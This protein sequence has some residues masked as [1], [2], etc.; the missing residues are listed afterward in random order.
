MTLLERRAWTMLVVA[1][2]AYTW[3]V[4][5]VL[6]RTGGT[7]SLADVPYA[8]ALLRSVVVAI[9]VNIAVE[10][11]LTLRPGVS[12]ETDV[13][14]REISWFGDRVGQ[15]FVVVA[16]VAAMLMSML[17]WDPFW[18]ANVVY[19]GFVLSAVVGSLAKVVTYRT[20]LPW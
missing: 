5:D 12:R 7:A 14:D 2:L 1:V 3:Y 15:G 16:A 6:A 17:E 11:V 8:A 9:G 20:G 4:V 19:L 10:I 18:V 13:R